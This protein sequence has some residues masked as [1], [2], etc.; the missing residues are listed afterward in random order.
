MK[1]PLHD[2]VFLRALDNDHNKIIY[3]KLIALTKDEQPIEA[4][5]GV[6][7]SGSIN[8]DG[9]SAV[10]RS[11]NLTMTTKLLN[12]NEVY[13]GF[14]TKVK[15]EI[16]LQNNV[17]S[18]YE[19]IIWFKQGIYILTDFKT[20]EQVNNYTITL[21]GKD[22]M[23]LL[24][25]DISGNFNA[26]TDLG[27]EDY[28]SNGEKINQ[29]VPIKTIILE[30]IHHYAQ[31]PWA[32]IIINNLEDYGLEMLDNKQTTND[33]YLWR[34]IQTQ[35]YEY[36]TN[37]V[38]QNINTDN[39][40]IGDTFFIEGN[41]YS[42][43]DDLPNTFIFLNGLEED[44]NLLIRQSQPSIII[45]NDAQYNI[46]K[47]SSMGP[48]GYRLTD[49]TYAGDLIAAPGDTITSILDKI[50]KMLGPFEYFY[51]LDGQFVFQAKP[52]YLN[53][54]W[55]AAENLDTAQGLSYITPTMMQDK[56]SYYF[57]NGLLTTAVQNNPN[58][59]NVR[60]DFTVWGKRKTSDG[61]EI[62]IH[63]RYAIDKKP[64]FYC[65]TQGASKEG[66]EKLAHLYITKEGL[67]LLQ[68]QAPN[69]ENYHNKHPLPSAFTHEDCDPNNWWNIEDWGEYYKAFTG[70]YPTGSMKNYQSSKSN[71]IGYQGNL[72]FADNLIITPNTPIQTYGT[73]YISRP[74]TA[75]SVVDIQRIVS[76]PN[77]CVPAG[78]VG[79][80]DDI[81]VTTHNAFMHRFNNCSHNYSYF[82]ELARTNNYESYFY[83]PELNFAGETHYEG[84]TIEGS[85]I[86][87]FNTHPDQVVDWRELIYQMAKDYYD[88]NNGMHTDDFELKL[89]MANR[90]YC[91]LF[92]TIQYL[93]G[94]TGYEQYY[95]DIEGFWRLL[96]SETNANTEHTE[97]VLQ[98]QEVTYAADRWNVLV[99]QDPT[100]LLFWFDFYD[101]DTNVGKFSVPAIGQRTKVIS[102]DDVRVIVY[103][104]VPDVIYY[105]SAE[106]PENI[107][108]IKTGY[109][110]LPVATA[111]DFN[112]GVNVAI[113]G[114]SAKETMDNLLYQYTHTNDSVTLSTIPIYYLQPN[115]IIHIHNELS[116][117]DG[118]YEA[119]KITLPLT[120]NGTMNISAVKIP[121]Q[122]Y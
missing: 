27:T 58:M 106:E 20:S 1:N 43:L 10:R 74:G 6:V 70:V 69:P 21:Q 94:R 113:R 59:L 29:S 95:H 76:N 36:L 61:R 96:Y 90:E 100:S 109:S 77:E 16:G 55:S 22:K 39:E 62:P 44:A 12:I 64:I 97:I 19:K 57:E 102:D 81:L 37:K 53:T 101:T 65:T 24:N 4:I 18:K 71:N 15:I 87:Y 66:T 26:E 107:L 33:Y 40:K 114:K 98:E 56:T 122:I 92:N 68:E 78:F 9:T 35:E 73:S 116:H 49:L 108:T 41:E 72:Y 23:C 115:S 88:S 51:N 11:C 83:K 50:V 117:I 103:P 45:L 54:T 104:D 85:L 46:F 63:A 8:I 111:S 80:N 47:I 67:A 99:K 105:D 34:N 17:D 25:G 30:M 2:T 60:N 28:I 82:L 93:N 86:A 7:Q 120:Y 75:F 3:A 38:L 118:Y 84:D 79:M 14:T 5:E 31:E 110:Y 13:W 91:K 52:T 112:K 121:Q 119:T 32:N 48:A 42:S 89:A